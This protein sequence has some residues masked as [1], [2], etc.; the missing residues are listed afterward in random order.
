MGTKE[1]ILLE[2]L[3]LFARDG[4]EAVSVRELAGK[5][6]ITQ[7]ALYRHYKSK[8]DI[9][10]S[11][12]RRMEENDRERARAYEVPEDPVAQGREPYQTASLAA[13]ASFTEAQYLYWTRD[14]F[15]APFR[16]MLTIEQY[17]SADMAALFGQYLGDGVVGYVADLFR[18]TGAFGI[19]DERQAR[20]AAISFYAPVYLLMALYDSARDRDAVDA[21]ARA[22]IHNFFDQ[23]QLRG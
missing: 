6:G 15:A 11:I 3:R 12:L 10:D 19:R 20:Q 17:R 18:E 23:N 5:I 8:R 7:G 1:K 2:A 16:R 21:Q 13:L 22:H 4:Y 14:E 9:F